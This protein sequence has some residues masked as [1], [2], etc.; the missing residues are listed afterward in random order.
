M[1]LGSVEWFGASGGSVMADYDAGNVGS[2]EVGVPEAASP[3]QLPSVNVGAITGIIGAAPGG[4]AVII[5]DIPPL[6]RDIP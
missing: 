6:T 5:R 1:L 2:V 4:G 3:N